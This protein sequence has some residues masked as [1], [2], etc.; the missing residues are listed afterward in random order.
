MVGGRE[1]AASF[2]PEDSGMAAANPEPSKW[3]WDTWQAGDGLPQSSISNLY[4]ASDGAFWLG[5]YDGLVRFD[6]RRFTLFPMP[7][8]ATLENQFW[9]TICEDEQGSL[10]GLVTDGSCYVVKSGELRPVQADAGSR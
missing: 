1:R 7:A 6:G 8:G 4:E 10:W 5:V 2:A 9:D 3:L